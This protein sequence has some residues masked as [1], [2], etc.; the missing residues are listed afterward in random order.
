MQQRTA[1]PFLYYLWHF[2]WEPEPFFNKESGVVVYKSKNISYRIVK[3]C[4][5]AWLFGIVFASG[6]AASY[7]FALPKLYNLLLLFCTLLLAFVLPALYSY[8]H[9]K[10]EELPDDKKQE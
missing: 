1:P 6:L 5:V 10:F 9:T 8:C 7:F 3:S 2:I 4:N